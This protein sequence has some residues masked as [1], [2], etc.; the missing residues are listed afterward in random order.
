[1]HN[2]KEKSFLQ[3]GEGFLNVAGQIVGIAK[4]IITDTA[5]GFIEGW[6]MVERR[7]FPFKLG[8][9]TMIPTGKVKAST[10]T[11]DR[12]MTDRSWQGIDT[13][14]RETPYVTLYDRNDNLISGREPSPESVP[15]PPIESVKALFGFENRSDWVVAGS[16]ASL[17]TTPKTEGTA[18]LKLSGSG[19][20]TIKSRD[21]STT[22]LNSASTAATVDVFL[23]ANPVNPSY[24]GTVELYADCPSA[25]LTSVYLGQ[26][27]LT[28]L[29]NNAYSTVRFTLSASIK[30]LLTTSRRDLS[31]KLAVNSPSPGVVLDRIVVLP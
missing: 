25:G 18:A 2:L 24:K 8:I 20:I 21:F 13:A 11:R 28:P 26:V 10:I 22:L 31:F 30:A 7:S 16:A 17:A 14:W 5:R 12:T 23:P 19:Y 4:A 27:A 6:Q 29:P 9:V 15:L 1:M 3:D